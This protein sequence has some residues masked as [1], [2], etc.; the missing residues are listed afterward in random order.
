ML[1][2]TLLRQLRLRGCIAFAA[3]G[4]LFGVMVG[5]VRY[6]ERPLAQPIEDEYA[7]PVTSKPRQ[8]FLPQFMYAG[9][10]DPLAVLRAVHLAKAGAEQN[11][12]L[13]GECK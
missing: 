12:R 8:H 2:I 10:S 6:A 1:L 4:I 7:A 9:Q 13:Y 5:M 11:C 3:L